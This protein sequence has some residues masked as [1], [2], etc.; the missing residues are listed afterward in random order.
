MQNDSL[1]ETT[2]RERSI[3]SNWRPLVAAFAATCLIFIGTGSV[4]SDDEVV[5]IVNAGNPIS[6]LSA[7]LPRSARVSHSDVTCS[8]S[9]G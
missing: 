4:A 3:R 7:S 8:G 5:L 6:S 9:V 2:M 1:G